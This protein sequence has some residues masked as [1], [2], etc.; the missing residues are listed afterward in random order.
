MGSRLLRGLVFLAYAF[1]VA[2]VFG[3]AAYTSFSLFVRSG[4]TTVPDVVGL[5][6]GDAAAR[7]ADQGLR[8]REAEGKGRYHEKI[9]AGRVVRQTP[10]PRTL[11]KR[12]SPVAVVMSLGPQRVEVPGLAEKPLP[13]AQAELSGSG[14]L[15]GRILGVFA[16]EQTTGT[17]L[18]QD[19]DPGAS[20]APSTPVNLLLALQVPGERYVMPDL[21]YRDYE[22]VRPYFEDRGFR[23]G[24]VRFERYEGVAAGIVLRQYPL[25]GHPLT[26]SDPISLVVATAEGLP[27]SLPDNLPDNLPETPAETPPATPPATPTP[28][29]GR[30]P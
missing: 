21:V 30:T 6:R 2:L 24:S 22:R 29:P 10:D 7:L 11:V 25:P 8:L 5:P 14:L 27:D 13:A 28:A 20:V 18:A 15:V 4:A 26:K 17:V 23:L 12:G 3:L 16:F 1:L 9:P 19:P